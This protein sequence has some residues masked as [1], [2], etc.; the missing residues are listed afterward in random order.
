MRPHETF[1]ARSQEPRAKWRHHLRWAAGHLALFTWLLALSCHA[2]DAPITPEGREFFENKIR[3]ILSAECN[4]CHNAIKHKGGL[5][6]DYRGGWQKGGD[7]GDDIVPGDAAKS[8][9][10]KSIRHEDPDLKMPAKSPKLDSKVIADFEKWVNMGAPDPRDEPPKEVAGKPKWAELLAARRTWWSLQPVQKPVVPAVKDAA[11]SSNPVDRFLLAKMEE[12]DLTPAKDADPRTFIR[13]LTF[14][15]TGLPPTP[16]EVEAFVGEASSDRMAAIRK[17][18]DRLLASPHF[19][20]HWARH[21]LDLVRYAETHGSEGDPEI[22][23]AW[24][25]RD[26]MISALNQDVPVDQ[27]IREN[28]AGDLLAHPRISPDGINQ[29]MLGIAQYRLVEHGFQP[30]DTLDD[31]VKV[32][33]NQ[34]DVVSKA[35]QGLTVACARC[36][37]HK[38]DAISQHDYYALFGIFAS[39]RPAQVTID[40]PAVQ[41]TNRDALEHVHAE[42]K[43]ALADAWLK[44]ADQVASRLRDAS[45]QAEKSRAVA[46]KIRDLEQQVADLEWSARQALNHRG[47]SPAKAE[48]LPSPFAAWSFEN[49]ANDTFGR[50]NGHLEG[51]AEIRNGRLILDGKGA[52]FRTDQLPMNLEAKTLEAWVSPATLDQRGGGV[53]SVESTDVHGFDSIVFAEREPRRWYPGSNFGL[54]SENVGGTEETAKPGELVHM[55]LVY[56][57]DNSIA[58]YRNGVPYGHSYT[59]AEMK[60]FEAGNARVLLGLRHK[61][62]GSGFF[63]GEIE[64]ARLYDRALTAEEVAASYH[65]GAGPVI[66]PEQITAALSPEQRQQRASLTAQIEK[67]RAESTANPAAQIWAQAMADAATNASN[68]LHLWAKLENVRDADLPA[69]WQKLTDP[70]RAKLAEAR[71]TNREQFKTAWNLA[72]ADYAKWFPYGPGL[73]PKPLAAGE[74]SIEPSGD[75]VLAGLEP[76]GA[77]TDRLSEK[78]TGI[79]TSPRFK[80]ESD[81]I[82]VRAFGAGGAM[83][84]VIVDNYPLP[85]NPIFPKAILEKSEPGWVRLDTAYRKGSYAYIEFA[86]HE[87]LTRPLTDKKEKPNSRQ[88]EP[89]SF[90]VDQVVFND[91]KSVPQEEDSALAPLLDGPAPKSATELAQTYSRAIAEAVQAWRNDQL[92]EAQ[93]L[94]LDGLVHR[95]VL[96]TTLTELAAVRP[97]VTQYRQLDAGVPQLHH[98]PG[99]LETAAYDAPFLPRG[100]HLKPGEPVPRRYLEVFGGQPYHTSLSGRRELADAIANPQNP[101]TARVMV[102]RIWHWLY[103][104]GIVATVDNFGRLG[105]KPTHPE[106]LDYLAARFV[107]HGWSMKDMIRYLVT[108]RAFGM[109]SEPS[110]KALASDPSNDWLSHMRVR[111]IEAESIRD[112]LLVDA[113]VLDD[114]MFGKPAD[115]NSSR[116]SIYLPVRRTFLNPFLQVFDAPRPFTTLGRRDATNVP[117]QSLTMLNSPFVIAQAKRWATALVQDSSDCATTRINRMFIAAFARP[118]DD[119]ELAAA[120]EYLNELVVDHKI[121]PEELL[122]SAPVWED[123]AQSLFNLKEFIYLR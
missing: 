35:F 86:T 94:F 54:R 73:T 25:Y 68:P 58:M 15:L 31:E 92:T 63:A 2:A 1:S 46:G 109:D 33:D 5:R 83:V 71:K 104:R 106:L 18:T 42:I 119:H 82:S 8:L 44:S 19:G 6:L 80:I 56:G 87:D 57:A 89:S 49:G 22:R 69:V 93:R 40:S 43:S 79:L 28:L 48:K 111:R 23:E 30:V 64:E 113:G 97:L 76:G 103:G 105:E 3:P 70:L 62:A 100:D 85:N 53:V 96:P 98:A 10:I 90:G 21:W 99:V 102:N 74:F 27:L 108:T 75:R 39:C 95:G 45:A 11:W 67:L 37:D 34:I 117:A 121:R 59:K 123:F 9:L 120:T 122:G 41:A 110:A 17:A 52:Y 91:G 50:L 20:E 16:E 26:Y 7:N 65:A 88:D 66:T 118:A 81:S 115:I 36:H 51:G 4:E 78:H 24:R 107:E 72:G 77:F 38:F 13:R 47:A 12:H 114:K 112:S 29:S 55:A 116:R 84:R 32:V 60:K 14:A 61:G 101:L